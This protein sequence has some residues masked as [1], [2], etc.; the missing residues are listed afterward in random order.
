M[1]TKFTILIVAL[2]CFMLTSC[3]QLAKIKW[4]ELRDES[5]IAAAGK[6]VPMKKMPGYRVQISAMGSSEGAIGMAKACTNLIPN[7]RAH[8]VEEGGL[9]KIRMGDC[10]SKD[11]ASKLREQLVKFGYADCW[12]A[13]DTIEIPLA[14]GEEEQPDTTKWTIQVSSCKLKESA[15]TIKNTLLA[16]GL[17]DKVFIISEGD[18][19][20]V[21]AGQFNTREAADEVRKKIATAGYADAW[22]VQ[23]TAAA[24]PAASAGTTYTGGLTFSADVLNNIKIGVLKGRPQVTVYSNGKFAFVD[25]N[26]VTISTATAWDMWTIKLK[27]EGSAAKTVFRAAPASYSS[28]EGAEGEAAKLKNIVTEPVY[29]IFE[30]PWY[31]VRVGDCAT[32]EEA[33][34][35]KGKLVALGYDQTWIHQMIIPPATKAQLELLTPAEQTFGVY[36]DAI[37]LKS[38]E[39]GKY[40]GVA[41]KLYRRDLEIRLGSDGLITVVNKL[42]LDEYVYGVVPAEI[43]SNAPLEAQ[44]AQAVA[45]RT[46]TLAKLGR[47]NPDGFDLCSEVHCQAYGGLSREAAPTNKS[48]DETKGEV[49]TSSGRLASTVY[50]ACCGGFLEDVSVIWGSG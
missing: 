24:K 30:T 35:I 26:N 11:E 42:P 40:V 6:P 25:K 19:Y 49:I 7:V 22:L 33:E 3:T 8:V 27:G 50:H 5:A 29:V 31:K 16:S 48:V 41:G 39:D 44:K 36:D 28:Q 14:P 32:R 46:E 9:Y 18:L 10:K 13:T 34:K 4:L 45:A 43:G 20:R 47:H 37:F 38:Q 1:K 17:T 21:R 2:S 23:P 12:I 15:D